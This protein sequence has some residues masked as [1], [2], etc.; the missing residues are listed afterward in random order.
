LTLLVVSGQLLMAAAGVGAG[1]LPHAANCPVVAPGT[2][3][4]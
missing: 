2:V 3:L 4:R 1:V